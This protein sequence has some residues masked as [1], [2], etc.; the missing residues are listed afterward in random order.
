[1]LDRTLTSAA[2][3]PIQYTKSGDVNIAY[4]VRGS[5]PI[6]LVYVPGWWS[7]LEIRRESP[8]P[9]IDRL[10]SFSRLI[11][12]DKRGTGMSDRVSGAV[13][14]EERMDDV[15][16]VMD[17]AGSERA[18]VMGTSEGGPMSILFAATY[19][20]RT[21]ALI[22]IGSYARRVSAPDYPWAPSPEWWA[23]YA[24]KIEEHWGV[25]AFDIELRLPSKANDEAA[26]RW[27]V[28]SR[29]RSMSPGAARA[30]VEMN[31]RIDV[32]HV[33]PAVRVPTL[34]LHVIGDRVSPIEGARQMAQRI[35]N[36]KL[37]EYEGIDHIQG[38]DGLARTADEI[39][40]FLTGARPSPEPQRVL[41]TVLFTD[42]VGSTRKAQELGDRAWRDLLASHH[43][44]VR[45]LL[46]L[47]KGRE[48][49][50][51]GDGFL[52]AFDGPARA[53][54]CAVAV[55]D[56]LRTHGIDVRAG[57]HTGECELFEGKLSG[58]AVH[59]G[60]RIASLA[61]AREILASSTVHDLVAGSGIAFGEPR[62]T[63]LRDVPGEWR[64]YR[65]E[66]A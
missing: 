10:A 62:S 13:T 39:Q 2:L 57:L 3:P 22:L 1:M 5:G 53:I 50:T 16:A 43:A 38:P 18:A 24:R 25:D 32:R 42:I 15:R 58:I 7:H 41:A 36:A 61:G 20:E 37:V 9:Y 29:R 45:R 48:I 60:S 46:E 51:S 27:W 56:A 54:R 30:L 14:L 40:E 66:S 35:P 28:D 63:A 52:A 8:S 47:Y 23:D 11:L 31:A 6:D 4:E 26:R 44:T 19:P 21:V 49:D 55:R 34:I 33:L 59:I 17:A 12:F 65:V 64:I